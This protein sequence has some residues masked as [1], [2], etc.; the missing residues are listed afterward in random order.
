MKKTILSIG[1]ACTL[2][3]FGVG[4]SVSEQ[5]KTNEQEIINTCEDLIHWIHEDVGNG[6]LDGEISESYLYNIEGIIARQEE[7]INERNS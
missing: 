7:I 2:M 6:Y 1:V 4:Y 3:G 5:T